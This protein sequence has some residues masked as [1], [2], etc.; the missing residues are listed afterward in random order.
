M[1]EPAV[2][3]LRLVVEVDD[4]DE[5][6]AFYRDVLGLPEELSVE[7]EG[8]ARVMILDAGRSLNARILD[9][10]ADGIT[11]GEHSVSHALADNHNAWR[12]RLIAFIKKTSG[13]K[14]NTQRR[15]IALIDDTEVRFH[16][17]SGWRNRIAVDVKARR[18]A[19]VQGEII[20]G[21]CAGDTGE[22]LNAL[23]QLSKE[24]YLLVRLGIFGAGQ[25]NSHR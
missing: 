12:I 13:N 6:V 2:S 10:A 20:H 18:V 1:T 11:T 19:A 3:Q 25:D 17:L 22:R 4:F 16:R 14:R 5:A 15:K 21:P 7:G 24:I 23:F 9:S 8:D